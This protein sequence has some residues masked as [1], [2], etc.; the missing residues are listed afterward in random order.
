MNTWGY[1]Y[2]NEWMGYGLWMGYGNEWVMGMGYGNGLWEWVM[3][4]GMGMN[5]N[6]LWEWMGYEYF[7]QCTKEI[8]A[9][10]LNGDLKN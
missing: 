9:R 1:E 5:G 6:G 10:L 4:M 7:S 2:L 3:G 8:I